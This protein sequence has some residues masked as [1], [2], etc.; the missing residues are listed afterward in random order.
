MLILKRY[1]FGYSI[2]HPKASRDKAAYWNGRNEVGQTVSSGTYFY[3]I[4]AGRFNA[5]KKM[6]IL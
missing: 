4:Q 1:A 6:M 2:R 5:V 3:Q